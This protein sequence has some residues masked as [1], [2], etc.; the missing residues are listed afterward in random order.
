VSDPF[1]RHI[2]NLSERLTTARPSELALEAIRKGSISPFGQ[3]LENQKLNIA[4]L[5][6]FSQVATRIQDPGL[7]RILFHR[8][9]GS[10]KLACLAIGNLMLEMQKHKNAQMFFN[11][12]HDALNG[13]KPGR[14]LLH[15]LA[16]PE[17]LF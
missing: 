4:L 17:H 10:D 9:E 7:L 11:F 8:G 16:E 6:Y 12:V 1:S 15:I 3:V 5:D 13:K 14:F 2:P